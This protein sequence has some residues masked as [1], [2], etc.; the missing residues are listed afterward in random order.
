MATVERGQAADDRTATHKSS[1]AI[2]RRLT[3]MR[4][5]FRSHPVPAAY[6][7]NQANERNT[8][9]DS[10]CVAVVNC[11]IVGFTAAR[12]QFRIRFG[13]GCSLLKPS[14][15]TNMI[16]TQFRNPSHSRRI[17][18]MGM[19]KEFKEFAVKGNMMDM[20]VGI[21]IGAAFGKIV[22]SVVA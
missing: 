19:A 6:V 20:A 12:F 3:T 11:G 13:L 14:K 22:S 5:I 10:G 7:L 17:T 16:A 8:P 18:L 1:G 4:M 9:S 15:A 2:V 21:I